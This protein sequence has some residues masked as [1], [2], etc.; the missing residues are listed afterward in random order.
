MTNYPMDGRNTTT[1]MEPHLNG[2]A[3]IDHTSFLKKYARNL[4]LA[5]FS[6]EIDRGIGREQE[7]KQ[8]VTILSKRK[9]A[10]PVLVGP[11]GTGKSQIVYDLAHTISDPSYKGPLLGKVIWEVSTTSITAGCSLVGMIEERMQGLL[12]E[13]QTRPEVILFWDELHTIIGAGQGSNGHNDA[14]NIVKPALAGRHLSVIGATTDEEYLILQEDKALNRRFNK[15]SVKELNDEQVIEVLKGIKLQY[16]RFHGI[17]FKD[18]IIP[19]IVDESNKY[20][21]I[22]QPDA[23]IDLLDTIGAMKKTTPDRWTTDGMNV[24]PEDIELGVELLY[25]L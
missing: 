5:A 24:S 3:P 6:G 16:E 17:I 20:S 1:T 4:N 19:L 23:A 11:P 25:S 18:D 13:A 15:L 12:N 8:L 22:K 21:D 10:N 14:A 7:L 2:R 9:K